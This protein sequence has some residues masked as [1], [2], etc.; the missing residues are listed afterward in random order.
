MAKSDFSIKDVYQL[1]DQRT[2]EISDKLDALE[3]RVGALEQWKSEF[4]GK[5]SVI[6]GFV[7][8]S[9]SLFS[10]WVRKQLNI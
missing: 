3:K 9:A 7:A 6:V 10:D 1:V 2:G 5:M 8:L 4:V